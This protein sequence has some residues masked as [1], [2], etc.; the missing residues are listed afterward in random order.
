MAFHLLNNM[1][2]KFIQIFSFCIFLSLPVYCIAQDSLDYKGNLSAWMLYNGGNALP[3]YVGGRYIPQLNYNFQLKNDTHFDFEASFNINGSAGID[4]FD[5]LSADGRLKPYRLWARYSSRQFEIRIGLQKINFGSAS[6]LRPLMWFDQVDPRD[7]LKLTDGVWGVL[8]RYYFLNNANIWLWSLYGNKSPKGWELS[9]TKLHAPEAGG[10]IQLPVPAGEAAIT[11]HYRIADTRNLAGII[12][13]TGEVSENR[14]GFDIKLDLVAGFW[15]EGSWVTKSKDLGIYTNQEI[16]N[17]GLDYTF[18]IGN[19]LYVIYEQLLTAYDKKAFDLHNST[20]FSLVSLSYP[21]T[22]FD[23]ISAIVYY[24]WKNRN[25]YNFLNWQKQFNN[26]TLYLMGYW[27][28]VDYR[29]PAQN[30]DQPLF[31]GRGVQIMLVL[32]H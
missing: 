15:F 18:G 31:G 9:G 20:S 11:Y 27:N 5:S 17:A 13:Q 14:I 2:Q 30:S 8:G 6:L 23:K 19:G 7:P 3:L 16:L 10:R 12:P 32:N 28:P 21:V 4:P 1:T 29:I 25:A 24:D 26:I 22:L